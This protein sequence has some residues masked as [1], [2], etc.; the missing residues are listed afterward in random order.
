M[1][2][3]YVEE[4]ELQWPLLV[5]PE[6]KLY[7]AYGMLQASFWDIWGPSTWLAYARELL[8]GQKL[9]ESDEDVN[10][11]G[12]DVLI[13]PQGNVRLHHIGRGPADRPSVESIIALI[14]AKTD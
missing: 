5:D 13:D 6:R 1:A 12:G 11:R 3:A 9:H 7:Q 4:T 14:R 10:Q 8:R 2:R